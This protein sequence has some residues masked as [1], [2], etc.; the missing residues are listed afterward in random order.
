MVFF[1]FFSFC[2]PGL[3]VR[4]FPFFYTPWKGFLATSFY[5]TFQEKERMHYCVNAC[6]SSASSCTFF[7]MLKLNQLSLI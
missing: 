5:F 4:A 3:I 7:G 6:N 2:L 1:F